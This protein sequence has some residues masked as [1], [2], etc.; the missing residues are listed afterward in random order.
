MCYE[1]PVAL[2]AQ[3]GSCVRFKN[4]HVLICQR[5]RPC[6]VLLSL[7]SGSPATSSWIIYHRFTFSLFTESPAKEILWAS[8]NGKLS[9]VERLILGDPML[10]HAKDKDGYTPLHRACYND[11]EHIVDVSLCALVCL[12]NLAITEVRMV[13]DGKCWCIVLLVKS[14]G[15]WILD[16]WKEW[17]VIYMLQKYVLLDY[18]Q[19]WTLVNDAELLCSVNNFTSWRLLLTVNTPHNIYESLDCVNPI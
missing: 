2:A 11:H 7:D 5:F 19:L 12:E 1:L 17:G 9:E 18:I 6:F 3:L 8:E 14:L 15:K 13:D 16:D 10:I 4:A